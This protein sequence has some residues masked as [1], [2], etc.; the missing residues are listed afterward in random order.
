MN[1]IV[2]RFSKIDLLNIERVNL[3]K[4]IRDNVFHDTDKKM[5]LFQA[6]CLAMI[7]KEVHRLGVIRG[8]LIK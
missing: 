1:E 8:Q 3:A 2:D 5:S 7:I 6:L 4:W